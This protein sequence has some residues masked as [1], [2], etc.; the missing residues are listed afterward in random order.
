MD[1]N[2][3]ATR[4]ATSSSD[5]ASYG[6]LY[7][8]G[9]GTDG[10]QSRTSGKTI[11]TSSSNTPG[12][13]DFITSSGDWRSPGND[14]L[15]QGISGWNNPCPTGYL[16]PTEAEWEAER[17]SWS[18]SNA[19]GAFGSQLKLPVA[20]VRYNIDGSLVDVGTGGDY[21]SSTVSGTSAS[22]LYFDSS[23]AAIYGGKR[24]L[25]LSVRCIKKKV[26]TSEDEG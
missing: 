15:W 21:W 7:Q 23:D 25:G 1:R 16:L 3:G 12:N 20:G 14:D 17:V 2:L 6:D 8:W 22:Y 19:A 9:R 5:A 24:A 13:S 4:V 18:S 11:T 10:H 26:F